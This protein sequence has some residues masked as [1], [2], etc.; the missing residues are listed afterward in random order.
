LVFAVGCGKDDNVPEPEGT[1]TVHMRNS[2]NGT[3]Y[4]TPEGCDTFF[5]ITCKSCGVKHK[6]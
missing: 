1:I 3:T 5:G 2:N 6:S 4:I